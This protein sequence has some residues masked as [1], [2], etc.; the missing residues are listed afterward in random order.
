[1]RGQPAMNN[2][3]A[4]QVRHGIGCLPQNA[5]LAGRCEPS[6]V[7]NRTTVQRVNIHKAGYDSK[8]WRLHTRAHVEDN[9]LMADLGE[10]AHVR[11][12]R[13]H[14][15]IVTRTTAVYVDVPHLTLARVDVR[16]V[17]HRQL[18]LELE[19]AVL[20]PEV[21]EGDGHHVV[22]VGVGQ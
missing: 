14:I 1:M 7:A 20:E 4:V 3:L 2:A 17:A 10:P 15:L 18:L 12:P 11:Q 5:Q 6:R 9:V 16:A 8:F 13:F 21:A 19:L 22:G